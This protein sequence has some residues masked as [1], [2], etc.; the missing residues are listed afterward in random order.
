MVNNKQYNE[1]SNSRT[2]LVR[3]W[4]TSKTWHVRAWWVV[5]VSR[6]HLRCMRTPH[7][8]HPYRGSN[9]GTNTGHAQTLACIAHAQMLLINTSKCTAHARVNITHASLETSAYS[10]VP[11]LS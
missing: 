7:L 1:F 8:T 6:E 11:F 3:A 9:T 5:P 10:V 2:W 4:C